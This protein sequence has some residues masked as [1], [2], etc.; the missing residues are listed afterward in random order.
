MALQES[1]TVRELGRKLR[2]NV[3]LAQLKLKKTKI[4]GIFDWTGVIL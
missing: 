2:R 4:W 1:N 3:E